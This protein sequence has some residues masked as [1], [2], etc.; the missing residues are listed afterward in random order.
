MGRLHSQVPGVD[1]CIA[2]LCNLVRAPNL[3][4]KKIV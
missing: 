4:K 2:Q 1:C 3:G